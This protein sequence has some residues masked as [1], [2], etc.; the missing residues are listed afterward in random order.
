MLRCIRRRGKGRIDYFNPAFAD[1]DTNLTNLQKLI[2]E[3]FDQGANICVAPEAA[4][5]G[6]CL[7]RQQA[8]NGLGFTSPFPQLNG[9]RDLAVAHHGYVIVSTT[10]YKPSTLADCLSLKV[11]SGLYSGSLADFSRQRTH[12]LRAGGS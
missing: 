8:L 5:T 11:A 6:Y 12:R 10:G 9:I 1:V 3:A 2:A 4:T 7:T